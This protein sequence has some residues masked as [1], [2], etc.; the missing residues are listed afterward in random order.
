MDIK[1]YGTDDWCALVV[2]GKIFHKGHSVPKFVWLELLTKA[3]M[4]TEDI[5]IDDLEEYQEKYPEYC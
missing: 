1:L 2:D 4:Q 3:G 5:Y